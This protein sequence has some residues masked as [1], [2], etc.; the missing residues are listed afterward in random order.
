MATNKQIRKSQFI[1]QFGIGAI[2]EI[3]NESLV[4]ADLSKRP[5]STEFNKKKYRL[6]QKFHN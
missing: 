2:V 4:A 5:W 6:V 1:T 3:G